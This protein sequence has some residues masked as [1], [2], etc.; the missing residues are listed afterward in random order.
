MRIEF[1][2]DDVKTMRTFFFFNP[3]I[4]LI[5]I[6]SKISI[7]FGKKIKCVNSQCAL[8]RKLTALK[9]YIH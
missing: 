8:G 4:I 7:Y 3:N 6:A 9:V 1:N 5:S 2:I